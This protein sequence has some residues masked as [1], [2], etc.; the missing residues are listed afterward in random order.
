MNTLLKV[1]AIIASASLIAGCVL[2]DLPKYW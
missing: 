1:A 2:R